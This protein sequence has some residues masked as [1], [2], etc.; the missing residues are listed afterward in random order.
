MTIGKDLP[1][2]PLTRHEREVL[3]K[4]LEPSFPGRDELLAQVKLA[5]ARELD[6]DG[7]IEFSRV[8]AA[9]SQAQF[10]IPTEGEYR[11]VE[12]I[13]LHVQLHV[14]DG[15]V[16]QLELY[17]EDGSIPTGLPPASELRVFAAHSKEAGTWNRDE[18]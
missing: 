15:F 12:G 5:R 16:K 8:P 10:S 6:D 9:R 1:Y 18:K 11:D 4:L 13:T 7:C 17:K 3:D 2:R 14:V